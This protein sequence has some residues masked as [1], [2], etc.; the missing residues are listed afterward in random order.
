M[1][2]LVL[3]LLVIL[4][5]FHM[6]ADD[7]E[8]KKMISDMSETELL[9]LQSDIKKQNS[10]LQIKQSQSND[11]IYKA[12]SD[13]VI[14]HNNKCLE[15]VEQQLRGRQAAEQ[16]GRSNAVAMS[17]SMARSRY[18]LTIGTEQMFEEAEASY[19]KMQQKNSMM[20]KFKS[21]PDTF[22]VACQGISTGQKL[23]V[24]DGSRPQ[25]PSG[26]NYISDFYRWENEHLVK[27]ID[28]TEYNTILS[29]FFEY[30]KEEKQK[31]Q[32]TQEKI[33]EK[34]VQVDN[35]IDFACDEYDRIEYEIARYQFQAEY[36]AILGTMSREE[37]HIATFIESVSDVK[38]GNS[39]RAYREQIK[40][41]EQ[42]L[43]DIGYSDKEIENIEHIV[44]NDRKLPPENASVIGN[45]KL[46][47]ISGFSQDAVKT[48]MS[49]G[50]A[51]I[52]GSGIATAFELAPIVEEITL[53][54][55]YNN[56]KE[57][58]EKALQF[59]EDHINW[60]KAEQNSLKSSYDANKDAL[61]K[62]SESIFMIE[63]ADE[64][65]SSRGE[66]IYNLQRMMPDSKK[67]QDYLSEINSTVLNQK[68]T[69]TV[70]TEPVTI[71]PIKIL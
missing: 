1:K 10:E 11:K 3:C 46:K 29:L 2:R 54:F 20:K 21:Q 36:N 62:I 57:Q 44:F 55:D 40:N 23:S 4:L 27:F 19:R 6:I 56:S 63:H 70:E 65:K 42:K 7:E 17:Q 15:M 53:Y 69:V 14:K 52:V 5:P 68:P 34:L 31:L 25:F 59:T 38:F 18:N 16:I 8:F 13:E 43:L 60:L 61:R 35:L 28:D 71:S 30:A 51:K 67:V 26:G 49:P 39:A 37:E 48:V 32:E 24:L 50:N 33:S 58:A 64:N 41:I 47:Y 66:I 45:V 22:S 12:L 9:N